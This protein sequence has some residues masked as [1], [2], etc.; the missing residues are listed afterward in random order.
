M[1]LVIKNIGICQHTIL[2]T[3]YRRVNKINY[4]LSIIIIINV[5]IKH[6]MFY[7]LQFTL[8]YLLARL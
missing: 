3:K 7:V 6:S 5:H 1:T 2:Y 8:I 4:K